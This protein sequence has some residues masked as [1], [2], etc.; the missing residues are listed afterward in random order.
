MA[1]VTTAQMKQRLGDDLYARLTDRVNGATEN[2]TV[3]Q[4]IVD[5]AEALAHSYLA[6]RYATPVDL[7]AHPELANVLRS[8]VL[9]LVEHLAWRT[10][11]FVGNL[12]DRVLF[13]QED[14]LRWF[15][16]VA[17][18]RIPLPAAAPPASRTAE[19]DGPRFAATARK[20]TGDEL[21][22]L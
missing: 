6:Q 8:R 12:P 14:A 15:E 20:F 11:P 9:D 18:G 22:G 1:Y 5:E 19:N 21:D 4:A 2:A 3:A 7:T 10:S 13:M 17:S 16:S